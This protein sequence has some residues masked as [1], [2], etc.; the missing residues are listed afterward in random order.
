MSLAA[1]VDVGESGFEL[2]KAAF[3][4]WAMGTILSSTAPLRRLWLRTDKSKR[5]VFLTI[6]GMGLASLLIF[7]RLVTRWLRDEIIVHCVL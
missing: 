2:S 5:V 7:V 4:F 1:R 3:V 6:A